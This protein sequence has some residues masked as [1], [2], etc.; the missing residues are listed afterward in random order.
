MTRECLPVRDLLDSYLSDELLVETN[1]R[2]LSHLATC[3]SCAA[4]LER[5]REVLQ[6]LRIHPPVALDVTGL[7][8]RLELMIDRQESW[9]RRA[10]RRWAMAAAIVPITAAT[11]LFIRGEPVDALAYQD[12][13]ADH[14][15]CALTVPPT[16]RYDPDR[17]AMR[18]P[19]S[20]VGLAET[21]ARDSHG[22]VDAHLCPYQTR[23]YVHFVFR[24]RSHTFSLFIDPEPRG[25]LPGDGN[26]GG[27][28]GRPQ[29]IYESVVDRYR[30]SAGATG[31]Y[32]L[33]LVSPIADA[34]DR[35]GSGE[36]LTKS[37]GFLHAAAR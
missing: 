24:N 12:A 28:G 36:V 26:T 25:R 22:L 4:E 18:V 21:L 32:Q 33:L 19:P 31:H 23:T 13:I 14:V 35:A 34:A 6:T 17:T 15:A 27:L 30:V 2:I 16:A 7:R 5:R 3:R 37:V 10:A 9:M 8:T 11:W 1:H 20:L 29:P